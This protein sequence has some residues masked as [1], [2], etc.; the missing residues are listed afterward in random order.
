MANNRNTVEINAD[1]MRKFVK[2]RGMKQNEV[3]ALIGKA[4]SY[5]SVTM[6]S[7]RMP[8]PVAKLLCNVLNADLETFVP[9]LA[10]KQE[11][12]PLMA[13]DETLAALVACMTRVEKKINSVEAKLDRIIREL[14]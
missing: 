3:G 2:Q 5:F 4:D 12:L 13:D 7:G 10:P 8:L 9:S 6:H 14:I 1:Y 11:A